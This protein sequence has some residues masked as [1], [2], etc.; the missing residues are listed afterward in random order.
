[1]GGE[2]AVHL[3]RGPDRSSS[4]RWRKEGTSPCQVAPGLPLCSLQGTAW[5]RAEAGGRIS[6]IGHGSRIFSD[7]VSY[8]MSKSSFGEQITWV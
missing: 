2:A 5:H 4:W 7:T 6:E 3:L 1:M 8:S